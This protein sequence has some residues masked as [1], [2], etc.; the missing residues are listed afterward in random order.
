MGNCGSI[1]SMSRSSKKPKDA[2]QQ[3]LLKRFDTVE[4]TLFLYRS[5]VYR[6]CLHAQ[7][8]LNRMITRHKSC[9]ASFA[10]KRQKLNETMLKKIEGELDTLRES[11][12]LAKQNK[13]TKECVKVLENV[14]SLVDEV[15][16]MIKSEE[17][18]STAAT[19]ERGKSSLE[20]LFQKYE[21][22]DNDLQEL[23]FKMDPFLNGITLTESVFVK[24]SDL[25][26]TVVDDDDPRSPITCE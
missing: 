2:N 11:V 21:V 7:S 3:C 13:K 9:H 17:S 16:E 6:N 5:I 15:G 1:V 23:M 25:P 19:E 22:N 12:K 18:L 4:G 24:K 14:Y 8:Q 10:L 26:F 20:S